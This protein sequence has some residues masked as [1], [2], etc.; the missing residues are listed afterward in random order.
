MESAPSE[1]TSHVATSA[2]IISSHEHDLFSITVPKIL[3]CKYYGK[4]I[5]EKE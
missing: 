4:N 2:T 5:M 3:F 1:G